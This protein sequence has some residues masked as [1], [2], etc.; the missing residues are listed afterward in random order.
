MR[1]VR[2]PAQHPTRPSLTLTVT[3]H[4]HH[5]VARAVGELD[6]YTA[7]M[8]AA[9][10]EHEIRR[11]YRHISIDLNQV[12]S[13]DESSLATLRD[14]QDAL[15]ALGGRLDVRGINPSRLATVAWTEPPRRCLRLLPPIDV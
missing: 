4:N 11:G 10:V 13:I 6:A 15:R 14:A 7:T 3:T 12:H 8:L 5:V 1:P 9:F 2:P